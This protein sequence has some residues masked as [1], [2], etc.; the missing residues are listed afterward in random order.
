MESI[1][2]E[3]YRAPRGSGKLCPAGY[4]KVKSG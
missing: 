4:D 2:G 3:L 1:I